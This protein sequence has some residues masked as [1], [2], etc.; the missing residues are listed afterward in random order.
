M[1]IVFTRSTLTLKIF[2][3]ERRMSILLA[4]RW[5]SIW[6]WLSF[7]ARPVP[8]SVIRTVLITLYGSFIVYFLNRSATVANA[9]L[10]N[11]I[12]S[13]HKSWYALSVTAVAT[14]TRGMLRA[15]SIRFLL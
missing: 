15:E 2:S 11:T 1:F 10:V 4:P 7:S 3:T 6:Y 9:F 8:F 12:L 14:S 5:T 13:K